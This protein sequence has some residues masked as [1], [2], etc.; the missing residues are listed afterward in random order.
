MTRQE[1]IEHE[2]LLSELR[3]SRKTSHELNCEYWNLRDAVASVAIQWRDSKTPPD[4]QTLNYLT[5][6]YQAQ[7]EERPFGQV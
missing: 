4:E 6:I 5:E 2:K 7:M 3:E 1:K